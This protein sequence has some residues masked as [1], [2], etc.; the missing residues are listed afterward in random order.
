[1]DHTETVSFFFVNSQKIT[2]KD[3][4]NK[5]NCKKICT[6]FFP[7]TKQYSE[8][9]FRQHSLIRIWWYANKWNCTAKQRRTEWMRGMVTTPPPLRKSFYHYFRVVLFKSLQFCLQHWDKMPFQTGQNANH[10]F[11]FPD[12]V[13]VFLEITD[14]H[15]RKEYFN[16]IGYFIWYFY[17]IFLNIFPQDRRLYPHPSSSV[18]HSV[19]SASCNVTLPS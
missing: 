19:A 12:L 9:C 7:L 11:V 16:W 2:I 6:K 15:A 1:M 18:Q 14:L 3:V 8:N 17:M 5:D 13:I 4:A 10:C